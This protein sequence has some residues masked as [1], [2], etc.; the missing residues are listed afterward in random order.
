MAKVCVVGA[1]SMSFGLAA[2]KGLLYAPELDG[3]ELVLHDVA[4]DALLRMGELARAIASTRGLATQILATAD[5]E[6]ALAGADVVVLSVT[7]DRE[8][9]WR[10]DYE[11]GLRY[12]IKHYA[13]NGGPGAIF[14]TARNLAI[15]MP[16]LRQME[17][18]CPQAWIL[19]YT[20]PVPRICTAINR[21]SSLRAI[22]VCH[23]LDFGYFMA[24][25]LLG[26]RLGIASPPDPR[27]RWTDSALENHHDISLAA[28]KKMALLASGT[29]H[30]TWAHDVRERGTR[31]D[32]YPALREANRSFARDFEPFTREIFALYD[33]FPTPGDTHLV[34]YLPFTHGRQ[35][36][37]WT[38]Y[39]IQMYDF[40]WSE[41]RRK[42]QAELVRKVAESRDFS[43]LDAVDTER[44]ELL[45][46]ALLTGNC[47]LDEAINLPN[48]GQM[49][50]LPEAS[51]VETPGLF[52]PAGPRPLLCPPLPPAIR[53]L[54]HRQTVIN[55]LSVTG[56]VERN[57][58][59]LKDALA[60][61]PMIDDPLLPQH[62]LDHFSFPE[63]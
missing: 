52:L 6:Q 2:L 33:L 60:L 25:V 46:E 11:L 44:V 39:D 47:Y 50:G 63:L 53:E 30:F 49:P 5:P 28:R 26:E 54:C 18:L 27:F 38:R 17:R 16:L 34:E 29:N 9:K 24:G 48:E 56:I 51:I 21:Y 4:E 36:E 42:S 37:L 61:D 14:H 57:R 32:L 7:I 19:N 55:E 1:G 59:K 12:D 13:E 23:Q 10:D 43:L 40:A 62:F 3:I 20:N 8:A 31:K 22:G 58:Q 35:G 41:G 15:I 45:T